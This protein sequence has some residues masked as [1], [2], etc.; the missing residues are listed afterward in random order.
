[1]RLFGTGKET[2]RVE[3]GEVVESAVFDG[4]YLHIADVNG[5]GSQLE[6][7]GSQLLVQGSKP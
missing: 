5:N 7:Q 4:R 3:L 2:A 6:V 1:M